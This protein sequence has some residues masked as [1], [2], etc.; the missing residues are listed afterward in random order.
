MRPIGLARVLLGVALIA[1]S[2][3]PAAATPGSYYVSGYGTKSSQSSGE[4]YMIARESAVASAE[5]SCSVYA[6]TYQGE[7]WRMVEVR[8]VTSNGNWVGD[9]FYANVSIS[10][11]C[12][13][14]RS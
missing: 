10:A 8:T 7:D 11:K 13:V 9:W 1:G 2:A 6:N 5:R 14:T 3:A 4:A 12:I